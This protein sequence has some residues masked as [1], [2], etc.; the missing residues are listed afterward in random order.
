MYW[1]SEHSADSLRV[2]CSGVPYEISPRV[3]A[4]VLV[5]PEIPLS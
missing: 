2:G 4:I 5:R 1:F 3:V